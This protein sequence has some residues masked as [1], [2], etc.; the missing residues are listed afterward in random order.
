MENKSL[1]DEEIIQQKLSM[2]M[3]QTTYTQKEAMQKLLQHNHDH[4]SVIKEFMGID[5]KKE[6]KIRSVNQAIYSQLR[7]QLDASMKSYNNKK[8]DEL[9]KEFGK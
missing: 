8:N 5:K 7:H 4:I 2:I 9:Q 3:K 1:A 6:P